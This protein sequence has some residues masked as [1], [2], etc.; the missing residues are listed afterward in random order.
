MN[1]REAALAALKALKDAVT[2]YVSSHPG[3]TNAEVT[4]DLGLES[5]FQG[6]QKNYLAWSILGILVNEGVLRTEKV[7]ASRHFYDVQ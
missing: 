2:D 4:R 3:A 5:D 6:S 7:G 1:R